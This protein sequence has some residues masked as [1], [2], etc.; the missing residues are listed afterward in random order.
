[1]G[2]SCSSDSTASRSVFRMTDK[3]RNLDDRAS[4]ASMVPYVM[5]PKLIHKTIRIFLSSTFTDTTLDRNMMTQ[6]VFEPIRRMCRER[7]VSFEVVDLRWGVRQESVSD[8]RTL[9]IC[10]EEI[11]RCQETSLGIAFIAILGDK[12]GWKPLPP[13]V[14]S[15]EFEKILATLSEPDRE[16]VIQWYRRDDNALPPCYLLQPI[17][18]Q[19][20]V[21]SPTKD[22]S[23]KAWEQWTKTERKISTILNEAIEQI[24]LCEKE[25]RKYMA[26]VTEREVELGIIDD[27]EAP[28]RAMVIDRRF[29][30]IDLQADSARLYINFKGSEVDGE[31][32][33]LMKKLK[34]EELSEKLGTDR[35]FLFH[36]LKWHQEGISMDFHGDYLKAMC[37][38]VKSVLTENFNGVLRELGPIDILEE[39]IT[40]HAL[41][42]RE[43]TTTFTGRDDVLTAIHKH[44]DGEDPMMPLVIHG[45]SGVGKTSLV[46]KV[47]LDV[48]SHYHGSDLA[49]IYR[50]CGTTA[51]SSSGRGLLLSL[52]R[53]IARIYGV[54]EDSIPE[55]YSALVE[56]FQKILGKASQE[57]PLFILID[58]LDQLSD[59]NG[60]RRFLEWMPKRIPNYVRFI[61]TTLPKAGGCLDRLRTFG[62]PKTHFIEIKRLKPEDGP[63]ILDARLKAIGRTLTSKQRDV[64]T[65]AFKEC[66]LP[67]YMEL[68]FQQCRDWPSYKNPED[69]KLEA[70][71]SGMIN[72]FYES[73]ERYHGKLL[74]ERVLR[75]VAA[76]NE[77]VNPDELM[78]ILSCDD[79]LLDDVLVWHKPPQR[80]LPPLL[81]A[82]LR[83]DLG[84]FLVQRGSQG[85]ILVSLYHRQF[86]EVAQKRYLNDGDRWKAN[87]TNVAKYF[88]GEF[89]QHHGKERG[90]A[91]QPL[92]YGPKALNLRKL[93]QLPSALLDAYEFKTLRDVLCDLKFVQAKCMA[94]MA[95]DLLSEC[96][97][98]VAKVHEAKDMGEPVDDVI[99]KEL[100]EM[101]GFLRRETH[102][103]SKSALQVYQQ[104]QNSPVGTAPEKAANKLK[105]K[106]KDTDDDHIPK[107]ASWIE[108]INKPTETE[109]YK[110]QLSGHLKTVLS[111]T[112]SK[113]GNTIYSASEDKTVR[114][115]DR[116]T[117][118]LT[119]QL[120]GHN[121]A[122]TCVRYSPTGEYIATS[123]GDKSIHLWNP[124]NFQLEKVMENAHEQWINC[125]SFSPKGNQLVSSSL[126][127][128]IKIWDVKS[129]KRVA[130]LVG[131]EGHTVFCDW[132][133]T[134]ENM[135][136][137][138]GD[139]LEIFLWD[140]KKKSIQHKLIGHEIKDNVNFPASDRLEG[141]KI[142]D[143]KSAIW[144]VRFSNNGKMV[145]SAAVDSSVI[146]YSTENGETLVTF[147]LPNDASSVAFSPDD[148][149]LIASSSSHMSVHLF[150]IEKKE[151]LALLGGHSGWVMDISFSPDAKLIASVSQDKSVR[152]WDAT[153]A[154]KFSTLRF[155]SER[156]WSVA[157][158]PDGKWLASASDDFK[159]CV[160]N[161]ETY[162]PSIIY[163]GHDKKRTLSCGVRACTISNSGDL[164]ASGG[165]D[166]TIR[167]WTRDKG[168][169]KTTIRCDPFL[170]W[171]LRFSKDDK[172]IIAVGEFTQSVQV[173]D[174]EKETKVME[175][176][177][178]DRFCQYTE[179]SPNGDKIIGSS[180]DNTARIFN[181]EDGALI[182][183]IEQPKWIT[184]ASYSHDGSNLATCS[185]DLLVR[186]WDTQTHKIVREM[187]GHIAEVRIVCF[188]PD[189]KYVASA[190]LDQS[191]RIWD[192]E[193]GE[194]VHV[195][196]T[197]AGVW[198]LAWN[199][200][201]QNELTAGDAVGYVYFLRINDI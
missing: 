190:A 2:A 40:R 156:C 41:F 154:E 185:D 20:N 151:T 75:L 113:D 31:S 97:R 76:S 141:H 34:E 66:S 33:E 111:V 106:F 13:S 11:K 116:H 1:M 114:A 56:E 87:F 28:H 195:F 43:H 112:F 12:Y 119:G 10:L 105:Q 25:K 180:I 174:W 86:W 98:A 63:V 146:I 143:Y 126:D 44:I 110:Q 147:G 38:K 130:A 61:V 108:Y 172:R 123:S 26:S 77:G 37:A 167:V 193:N 7:G 74:V 161:M 35:F 181:A 186:I 129:G 148:Q 158:S 90:I 188:S 178:F 124:G 165:D 16:L 120:E 107:P 70:D 29:G 189:D 21:D 125:I 36:D 22:V 196:Y 144:C 109:A 3:I 79:T 49:I 45:E 162:K 93:S 50:F 182:H 57:L 166:L 88:S 47:V 55:T 46:A 51:D 194:Q 118:D 62:L 15:E 168:E 94:G 5:D 131:H 150:N 191:V 164:V 78:D 99:V 85:V 60:A 53:Q 24:E 96:T 103:I 71:V 169:T 197:A 132:S 155:H 159:V 73:L 138:C 136:A 104:T 52:C 177:G 9:A 91:A 83:H 89:H 192:V 171:C 198:A 92:A 58:S 17:S 82:R 137:S 4:L 135:V 200:Q 23:D 32:V 127:K 145:A 179:F 59:E 117:G 139:N 39:E 149:L 69:C 30:E 80:R 201:N 84:S 122:V 128:Q 184:C 176:D 27:P 42:C 81:L 64:V 134:D 65:K 160:W 6:E 48:Q 54:D 152:I 18:Q 19:F 173:W 102:I 199:P 14:P 170:P 153:A 133:P 115:W 100:E 142:I 157:Y 95:Y 183:T 68:A 72:A 101:L 163:E 67:L 8:H 121:G 175:L 187:P 140:V